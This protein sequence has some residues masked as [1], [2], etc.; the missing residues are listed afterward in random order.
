MLSSKLLIVPSLCFAAI[1]LGWSSSLLSLGGP[2]INS[3]EN[4]ISSLRRE[5]QGFDEMKEE[6]IRDWIIM[7]SAAS[8]AAQWAASTAEWWFSA[9]GRIVLRNNQKEMN[10][11][12]YWPAEATQ[13]RIYQGASKIGLRTST[14]SSAE[15][16]SWQNKAAIECWQRKTTS[17][18][19]E[20]HQLQVC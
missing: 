10:K 11:T 12:R 16:Y 15:R 9:N 1:L 18:R 2:S 8:T 4:L 7:G 19:A 5:L 14:K 17:W 13:R 20:I 3:L 6:Y